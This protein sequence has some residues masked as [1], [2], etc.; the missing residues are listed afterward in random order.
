MLGKV[1]GQEG[2]PW[3]ATGNRHR[4]HQVG[5]VLV[6]LGEQ[7]GRQ[8]VR[9]AEEGG[10]RGRGGARI[11]GVRANVL[12]EDLENRKKMFKIF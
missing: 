11:A 7:L 1:G 8:G 3:K 10:G 2:S 9:T 12:L 5:I 4:R 6:Q